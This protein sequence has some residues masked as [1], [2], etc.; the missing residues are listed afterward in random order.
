[1]ILAYACANLLF[2]KYLS[3]EVHPSKYTDKAVLST[4]EIQMMKKR[5]NPASSLHIAM[6]HIGNT[7]VPNKTTISGITISLKYIL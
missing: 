7:I 1:M 2:K 4:Q 5:I 3:E 6:T